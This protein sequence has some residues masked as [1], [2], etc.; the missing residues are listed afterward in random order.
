MK[1]FLTTIVM[2]FSLNVCFGQFDKFVTIRATGHFNVLLNGLGYN[3]VGLGGGLDFSLFSKGRLQMLFEG[4]TAHF[5]GDKVLYFDT[6]TGEHALNPSVFDVK[7]GPQY[8]VTRNIAIAVTYG[9]SWHVYDKP[10]YTLD[11][12]LKYSLTG[13]WGPR[14]K[15]IT[16]LFLSDIP[17]DQRR[18]QYLGFAA[19]IR[20]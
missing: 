6:L 7:V 3:E 11:Y 9:P 4:S 5:V 19:G 2:L 17:N 18:I 20:F 15:F 1:Y 16:K 12:G 13:F 8:F 14:R 10:S